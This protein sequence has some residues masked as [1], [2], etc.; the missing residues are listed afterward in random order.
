[1]KVRVSSGGY[2]PPLHDEKSLPFHHYFVLKINY[3]VLRQKIANLLMMK[4]RFAMT[5]AFAT[6]VD[7]VIYLSLV[8]RVFSP[9]VSNLIAYP[10]GVLVNFVLHRRFVFHMKGK[11][12]RTFLFSILV[13][14]GGMGLSTLLIYALSQVTFFSEH[15][16]VTKLVSASVVFFYNF[17]LKRFVF[18]GRFM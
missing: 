8:N 7:Y 5:G 10:C 12:A 18:E 9:V 13:S 17:Y 4:A 16:P 2:C 1:M 15:Q 14:A 3:P 11:P 6:G